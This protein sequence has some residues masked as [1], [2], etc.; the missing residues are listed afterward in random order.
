MALVSGEMPMSADASNVVTAPVTGVVGPPRIGMGRSSIHGWGVFA[1]TAIEAGTVVEVSPALVFGPEHEAFV[2]ESELWGL[3]FDWGDGCHALPLGH[4]ALFNHD[5][6]P[7]VQAQLDHDANTIEFVAVRNI[8][9][10]EE[11][12][13]RYVEDERDL[14]F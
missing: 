12:T 7:S 11:L 4:G 5:P 2:Q 8:P 13:L 10:G 14:W 3:T 9:A 1:L 6:S